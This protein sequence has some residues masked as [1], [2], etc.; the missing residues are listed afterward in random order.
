MFTTAHHWTLINHPNLDH[1][2]YL[3]VYAQVYKV[4]SSFQTLPSKRL[5]IFLS[6]ISATH[7]SNVI[8]FH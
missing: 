7:S 5:Q 8:A 3:L 4:V 1:N 6:P 2:S